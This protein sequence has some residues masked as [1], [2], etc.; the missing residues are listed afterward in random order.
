MIFLE[1]TREGYCQSDKHWNCFKSN[2]GETS[3]RWGGAPLNFSEHIDS[4]LN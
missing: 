2:A 1:R 4:I 3:V